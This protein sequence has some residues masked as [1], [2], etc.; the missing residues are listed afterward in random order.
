M[1][2]YVSSCML[3]V[4]VGVRLSYRGG[5]SSAGYVEASTLI[6]INSLHGCMVFSLV[7][8]G[9]RHAVLLP[10][11]R[12]LVLGATLYATCINILNIY[13]WPV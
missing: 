6:S 7:L 11:F 3:L 8:H 12:V 9:C 4:R 13:R 2:K 5:I 10:Y 1:Y